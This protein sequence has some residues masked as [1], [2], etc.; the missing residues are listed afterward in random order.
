VKT[1]FFAA[2]L[3]A[4]CALNAADFRNATWGMSPEQVIKSE[5][6]KLEK[7]SSAN[8]I[9]L[10]SKVKL[11]NYDAQMTYMLGHNKLFRAYYLIDFPTS[12]KLAEAQKLFYAFKK[13]LSKKYGSYSKNP[14]LQPYD[15]KKKKDGLTITDLKNG[16]AEFICKWVNKN[17]DIELKLWKRE[18][19]YKDGKWLKTYGIMINYEI[20]N[21]KKALAQWKQNDAKKAEK[22]A[23]SQL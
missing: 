12:A 22:Q 1:L 20:L 23:E 13:I 4:A 5:K 8:K 17:S 10:R 6:I 11:L 7:D 21:P 3:V 19:D 9:S 18:S 16:N 14:Y 2:S 15:P